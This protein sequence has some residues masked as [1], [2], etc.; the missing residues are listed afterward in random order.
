MG[1]ILISLPIEGPRLLIISLLMDNCVQLSTCNV[2]PEQMVSITVSIVQS[3]VC[4]VYDF[5]Q[6]KLGCTC[7]LIGTAN[8]LMKHYCIFLQL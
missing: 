7:S 4:R 3:K 8:G 1:H 2:G 5:D 6:Q